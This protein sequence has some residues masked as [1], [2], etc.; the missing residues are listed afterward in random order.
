MLNYQNSEGNKAC[1]YITNLTDTETSNAI[2]YLTGF[3]SPPPKANIK[4]LLPE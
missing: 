4:A 3:C 1:D 2:F